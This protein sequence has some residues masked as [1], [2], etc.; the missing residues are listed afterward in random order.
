MPDSKE[1]GGFA[2][3]GRSRTRSAPSVNKGSPRLPDGIAN[4]SCGDQKEAQME[5]RTGS[6]FI[7]PVT[8]KFIARNYMWRNRVRSHGRYERLEPCA[9][10]VACTVLRGGDGGNTIP[11]TRPFRRG[12]RFGTILVNLESRRGVGLLP[13]WE[14]ETPGNRIRPQIDLKG[15]SRGRGGAYSSSAA[16]GGPTGTPLAQ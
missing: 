4:I 6:Y 11:L 13:D 9:A 12:C 16:P 10:K 1:G 14:G 5:W 7:L 2:T 15:V 3:S 8:N